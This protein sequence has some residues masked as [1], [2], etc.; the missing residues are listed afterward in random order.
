MDELK[1]KLFEDTLRSMGTLADML[2]ISMQGTA[3]WIFEHG[4]FT[5]LSELIE[6]CG[7]E[8]EFLEWKNRILEGEGGEMDEVERQDQTDE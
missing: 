4:K 3:D 8:A 7:L 1:V 2:A 6:K 5:S